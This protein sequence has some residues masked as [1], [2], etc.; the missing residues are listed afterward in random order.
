MNAKVKNIALGVA[1]VGS[2]LLVGGTCFA[3]DEWQA[4]IETSFATSTTALIT[5]ITGTI[6][7]ILLPI[8]VGFFVINWTIRKI[9]G[10]RK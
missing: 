5:L 3:T 1:S 9:F 7:P 2:A 8:L 10:R 4:G 6:L